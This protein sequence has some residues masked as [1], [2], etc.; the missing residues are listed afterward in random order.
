MHWRGARFDRVHEDLREIE[1][2]MVGIQLGAEWAGGVYIDLIVDDGATFGRLDLPSALVEFADRERVAGAVFRV[3]PVYVLGEV[4]DLIESVPHRKLEFSLGGACGKD[5]LDFDQMLFG[6]SQGNFVGHARGLRFGERREGENQ[7]QNQN[8]HPLSQTTRKK[9]GATGF[10]V[11]IGVLEEGH[12]LPASS[13]RR[14]G[15]FS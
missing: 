12:F 8:P 4:A 1:E 6:R 13:L 10:S 7:D 11:A 15:S 5:D 3:N 2:G 14:A 9:D